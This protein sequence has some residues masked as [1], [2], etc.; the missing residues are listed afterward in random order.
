MPKRLQIELEG[1]SDQ[2]QRIDYLSL[3]LGRDSKRLEIIVEQRNK[4][5]GHAVRATRRP[6]PRK[7]EASPFVSR[8]R[9]STV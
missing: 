2:Q 1:T 3:I 4:N 7:P 9:R 5:F 6:H 8:L